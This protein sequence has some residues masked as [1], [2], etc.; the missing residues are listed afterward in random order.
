GSRPGR[1][2]RRL[3]A[4]RQRVASAR[5]RERQATLSALAAQLLALRWLLA[6]SYPASKPYHL[7][8]SLAPWPLVQLTVPRYTP[9]STLPPTRR[10]QSASTA[11]G[12]RHARCAPASLCRPEPGPSRRRAPPDPPS[13]GRRA[14]RRESSTSCRRDSWRWSAPTR[15]SSGTTHARSQPERSPPGLELGTTRG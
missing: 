5:R 9:Q 2:R 10:R 8:S 3:S 13:R 14:A 11:T 4:G 7:R 15:R 6:G 1:S 12:P